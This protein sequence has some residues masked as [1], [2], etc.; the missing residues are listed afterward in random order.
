MPRTRSGT[1]MPPGKDGIW[2]ARITKTCDDGA[3]ARP[4][5]SLGTTD[6][7]IA[8]RKL[9]K[10]VSAVQRGTDLE[11]APEIAES[12]QAV[13]EFAEDWLR[14]RQTQGVVSVE[15]ER[16]HLE[17]HVLDA[18][19]HLPVGDVRPSH[20]RGILEDIAE[21]TYAK[22]KKRIVERRYGRETIAKVRGILHG[23]FRCAHQD[24]LIEQNPVAPVR[25]P[26]VREVKR[27]RMI[28]TDDEFARFVAC[29]QVDVE[30]RM[31]SLVA[32]C[33]GGM[34]AGDLTRWDWA[35]LDRIHFAECVVPRAK[36]GTPQRLGV[37]PALAPILRAWWERAG[38][39]ECGPVFPSRHGK[40]AGDFKKSGGGFAARLRRELFRAGIVRMP[41]VEVPATK[42]GMRTDLGQ[43]ALGTQPGPNPNDPLYFET[44]ASL[45][46][47]FHSFRR[48]FNTALAE[49]N[50]SVQRA[51]ALASHSD[52]KTH[53]RYVMRTRGM[54]TIPDAALPRLPSALGDGSTYALRATSEVSETPGIGTAVTI[55]PRLPGSALKS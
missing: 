34:R 22:G 5:Y 7:S 55:Q 46:V 37:P 49:A 36:T 6:R 1:L 20:I 17:R 28:L 16:A 31:L 38:C 25:S 42:A 19:G 48:A 41:P 40:R 21:K 50:V 30:L 45:P 35:E 11:T 14:K 52:A 2:K 3:V 51:M 27:E 18:I 43:C 23:L 4:L 54:R 29:E 32:R 44:A 8:K 10:L 26:K 33:E 15:A 13:K 39:P 12:D 9:Q 53:M 47:D 24:D